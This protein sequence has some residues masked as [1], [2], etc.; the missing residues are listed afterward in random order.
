MNSTLTG[1]A[2]VCLLSAGLARADVY[3]TAFTGAGGAGGVHR[4]DNDGSNAHRIWA[5]DYATGIGFDEATQ[6]LVW[7]V[8]G[9]QVYA[10]EPDGSNVTQIADL[11]AGG[12]YAF[13]IVVTAGQV[14]VIVGF[15]TLPQ[16]GVYRMNL[17]GSGLAQISSGTGGEALCMDPM[18]GRLL[19][20]SNFNGTQTV[21][22][23]ELDGTGLADNGGGPTSPGWIGLAV[24]EVTGDV[25]TIGAVD[26][27]FGLQNWGLYR[28]DGS[29]TPGTEVQFHDAEMMELRALQVFESENRALVGFAGGSGGIF[30]IALDGTGLTHLMS[31][32]R[33]MFEF[34]FTAG[35]TCPADLDGSGTL[36]VDDIDAFATA[37]VAGDLAADLD[38]S[39]S[40]NIDDVDAFAAAF[41]AGCP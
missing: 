5:G 29:A 9:G 20:N 4:A 12:G 10:S 16:A 28:L 36:N 25:Y 19:W 39:G 15:G 40:L 11:S 27:G 33:W 6:T 1:L 21:Y 8:H 31:T 22:S 38:G 26:I 37:F 2:T 18:S 32:N 41:L 14:F 3:W 30:E 17:D 34:V 7:S 35:A 13:D 24:G 23:A